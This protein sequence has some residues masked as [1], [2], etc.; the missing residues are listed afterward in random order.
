MGVEITDAEWDEIWIMWLKEIANKY[1]EGKDD[2]VM[3]SQYLCDLISLS[4]SVKE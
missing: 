1:I 4:R 2:F 3:P